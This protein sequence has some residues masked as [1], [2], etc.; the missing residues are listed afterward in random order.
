M[1]RFQDAAVQWHEKRFP[2]A[3]P[4]HVVMKAMEELGELA[5]AVNGRLGKNSP[6]ARGE[7]GEEAADVAITILVLLGRWFPEVSW[8]AEVR[9]KLSILTDPTS[10]H[11]SAALA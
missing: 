11:R 2:D 9:E 7:V 6:R 1:E 5:G 10:G 4:E 3:G 8:E